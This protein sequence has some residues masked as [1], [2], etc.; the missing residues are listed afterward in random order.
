MSLETKYGISYIVIMR[1][2]DIVKK[3]AVLQFSRIADNCIFSDNYISANIRS[4]TNFRT[5]VDDEIDTLTCD[6]TMIDEKGRRKELEK[7]TIIPV[8]PDIQ[9]EPGYP[10]YKIED[11]GTESYVGP[12]LISYY[13]AP[14]VDLTQYNPTYFRDLKRYEFVI[15]RITYEDAKAECE[16][17]G[18]HLATIK[19][20]REFNTVVTLMYLD[21][22]EE[23][24]LYVGAE[25]DENGTFVWACDERPREVPK[26]LLSSTIDESYTNLIVYTD[27][28]YD[29]CALF[30]ASNDTPF[31]DPESECIYGYICEYEYK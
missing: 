8:N 13:E 4:V 19:N 11:D 5:C 31:N 15:D 12:E 26:S 22:F 14:V 7:Y 23:D 6:Y 3:Y 29:E 9:G 10:W 1:Y 2:L 25:R 18:G 20:M 28:L 16:K 17:K 30:G 21:D 27:F 24:A